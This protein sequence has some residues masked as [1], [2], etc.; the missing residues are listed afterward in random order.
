MSN[1]SKQ[2]LQGKGQADEDDASSTSSE[3][4][5]ETW[6]EKAIRLQTCMD[7]RDESDRRRRQMEAFRPIERPS[8]AGS[9]DN[10]LACTRRVLGLEV[11]AHDPG[12]VKVLK[13]LSW[14][15]LRKRVR[16]AFINSI[17]G[18]GACSLAFFHSATAPSVQRFSADWPANEMI[19][20]VL[21]DQRSKARQVQIDEL[22][23]NTVYNLHS[24]HSE[25]EFPSKSQPHTPKCT[26]KRPV[27]R[28]PLTDVQ[29]AAGF[30]SP[31]ILR[32]I[33][34]IAKAIKIDFKWMK[35]LPKFTF[36]PDGSVIIPKAPRPPPPEDETEPATNGTKHTSSA[37]ARNAEAGPSRPPPPPPLPKQTA[38]RARIIESDH[39]ETEPHQSK[40]ICTNMQKHSKA[41]SSIGKGKGKAVSTGGSTTLFAGYR[42]TDEE[43]E[44]YSNK[45]A[46]NEDE[47]EGHEY[48]QDEND[49]EEDE[50]ED[51]NEDEDEDEDENE[52][53]NDDDEE[54]N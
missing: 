52:N 40:K 20:T 53:G 12:L 28:P 17:S 44:E 42:S 4:G 5:V 14:N 48:G 1:R 13:N 26:E 24:E 38:R 9:S 6:K 46:T 18:S 29:K 19:K 54:E 32:K 37:T 25:Y 27:G 51:E 7:E 30:I 2:L 50:D 3:S 15:Y 49:E 35:S 39:E 16:D 43:M 10:D 36:T 45:A 21:R 22:V 34:D 8:Q 31:S 11:G 23:I 33:A 41:C 47:S